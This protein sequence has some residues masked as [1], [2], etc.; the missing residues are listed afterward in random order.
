MQRIGLAFLLIGA[1]L[2]WQTVPAGAVALR[3]STTTPAISAGADYSCA[4]SAN[5][6][7]ECWGRNAFGQLG[8]GTTVEAHTPVVVRR[9]TT[10]VDHFVHHYH[11]RDLKDVPATLAKAAATYTV[12][13]LQWN[14]QTVGCLD[15]E[16]LF[17]ALSKGLS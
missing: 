1:G 8:N 17:Y 15:D 12:G 5:R 9:L 14:G 10:A 11:P 6:A 13:V 16:L 7:V 4:L 2:V 3:A